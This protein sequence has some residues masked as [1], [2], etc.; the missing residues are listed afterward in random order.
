MFHHALSVNIII[1]HFKSSFISSWHIFQYVIWN[2]SKR[3]ESK[4]EELFHFPLNT[5]KT[6][7]INFPV[8]RTGYVTWMKEKKL[9]KSCMELWNISWFTQ[10]LPSC[11]FKST[12]LPLNLKLRFKSALM[13]Q[14]I[15]VQSVRMNRSCP[16]D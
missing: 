1:F 3:N 9:L 15:H 10:L 13:M 2:H 12:F 7:H 5:R 14:T 4:D 11:H 8:T 16:T 6:V